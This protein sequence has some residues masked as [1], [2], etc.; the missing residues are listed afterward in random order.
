[1]V[2]LIFRVSP[3]PNLNFVMLQV[4]MLC[5]CTVTPMSV[6]AED[7]ILADLSSEC[8]LNIF[9]TYSATTGHL[10]GLTANS[11]TSD[12]NRN[13]IIGNTCCPCP[14]S[15][16]SRLSGKIPVTLFTIKEKHIITLTN[17]PE[18]IIR[19]GRQ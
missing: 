16:V 6:S 2:N 17:K 15:S 10:H 14:P 11:V 5:I 18:V 8:L 3:G 7:S 9:P 19:Y 4:L 13:M 1:M 12:Y